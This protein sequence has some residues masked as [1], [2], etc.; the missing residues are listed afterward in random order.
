MRRFRS[1][2]AGLAVVAALA[3]AIPTTLSN[4]APVAANGTIEID[5]GAPGKVIVGNLTITGAA[6]D[7]WAG[8]YPCAS[9]WPGTSNVNYRAGTDIANFVAVR[10]DGAGKICVRT[11]QQT[12]VIFDQTGEVDMAVGAS[13]RLIDTRPTGKTTAGGTITLKTGSPGQTIVGNV[14][15]VDPDDAGFVALYPCALGYSGTSNLNHAP[16]ETIANAFFVQADAKGEVCAKTQARTDLLVDIAGTTS[17]SAANS[18][19]LLDTRSGARPAANGVVAVATGRPNSTFVG[20]V[21]ITG[22]TGAGFAAAYGCAGGWQGTSN[23]NFTGS[24]IANLFVATADGEGKVCIR[25]SAS[26]HVIV[27]QIGDAPFAVHN[28]ERKTDTRPKPSDPPVTTPPTTNP[29]DPPDTT[30]PTTKPGAPNPAPV[31]GGCSMFPAD[32]PWNQ[33]V[34]SMAVRPE[35]DTWVNVMGSSTTLRF[36]FGGP[37]GIPFTIVPANQAKIP[38]DFSKG[39][40]KESDAGPYPIPLNA[41]IETTNSDRHTLALQQGSCKIYELYN[42]VAGSSSWSAVSGA[43]WDLSSNGLRPKNFTSADAAGLPILPGLMR[44]EDIIDGELKHP[45]R[46]TSAC[47]QNAFIHPAT[48]QSGRAGRTDCPPMGA[49]FRLKA[50][51][52]ISGYTGDARIILEGFKKYGLILA[53]NGGNWNFQGSIDSRW[54]TNDLDQI[55][56]VPGGAFEAVD[57]GPIIQP[58]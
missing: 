31:L 14:T 54:N 56:K 27:D 52:D 29:N 9:G 55:Y 33:R 34:D 26:A 37:Y 51:F 42:A 21:T 50:S 32:N 17:L 43:T 58:V 28:A 57:S 44:Y 23:V 38:V 7:G 39:Y 49:R 18:T 35:S 10:A 20:N 47:T 15:V 36:N 3:V 48:H 13:S 4:A 16:R 40:P 12:N 2:L 6:A 45:V 46:F 24:N 41:K 1:P 11:Q 5:T 25:T 19:R 53:D 22:A 30:P 8:V